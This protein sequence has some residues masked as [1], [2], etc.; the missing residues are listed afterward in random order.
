MKKKRLNL[1]KLYINWIFKCNQNHISLHS[2]SVSETR[3]TGLQMQTWQIPFWNDKPLA[4]SATKFVG[5]TA[6]WKYRPSVK[7]LLKI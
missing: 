2:F 3:D 4:E 1:T 6:K 5:P 7:N